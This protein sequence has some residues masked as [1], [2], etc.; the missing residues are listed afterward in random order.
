[1]LFFC[2]C[3]FSSSVSTC[4]LGASALLKRFCFCV[5]CSSGLLFWKIGV[6][7]R[8][9]VSWDSVMLFFVWFCSL[10][11]MWVWNS[12]VLSVCICMWVWI[13]LFISE[14]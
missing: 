1:M 3:C 13:R 7:L 11:V 14:M 9:M 10:I 12:F 5:P 4:G 2:V 6:L 8:C